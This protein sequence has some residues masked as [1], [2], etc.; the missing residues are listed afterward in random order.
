MEVRS[1]AAARD[2]IRSLAADPPRLNELQRE[3][4]SWWEMH[5]QTV[6]NSISQ[7]V[8]SHVDSGSSNASAVKWI[9]NLPC[10]QLIELARHQSG[11]AMLRRFGIQ[12]TRLMGGVHN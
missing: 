1:W 5:K 6:K 8:A 7:F 11:P 3:I 12:A 4:S 9:Y 2:N 10:W